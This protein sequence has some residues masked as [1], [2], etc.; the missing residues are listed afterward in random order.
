MSDFNWA[1]VSLGPINTRASQA[2]WSTTSSLVLQGN[3]I[4]IVC[5]WVLC[6]F[7]LP[8]RPVENKQGEM[9]KRAGCEAGAESV[10]RPFP[11]VRHSYVNNVL[12]ENGKLDFLFRVKATDL[13]L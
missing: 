10:L 4:W 5:N 13:V 8:S 1:A 9:N 6:L 3:F 11:A 7:Q 12:G 2:V